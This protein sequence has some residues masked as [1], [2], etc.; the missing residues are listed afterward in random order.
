M[1]L[2]AAGGSAGGGGHAALMVRRLRFTF[3][4]LLLLGV[5]LSR[6]GLMV[7]V[8]IGLRLPPAPRVPHEHIALRTLAP[9]GWP[10][11]GGDRDGGVGRGCRRRGSCR[12]CRSGTAGQSCAR[13]SP[14]LRRGR[15]PRDR[16]RRVGRPP[17]PQHFGRHDALWDMPSTR[18]ASA[19]RAGIGQ[20]SPCSPLGCHPAARGNI[21]WRQ[22][23]QTGP[24]LCAA[25]RP[26]YLSAC[27]WR[28][29]SPQQQLASLGPIQIPPPAFY[30]TVVKAP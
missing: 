15:A 23:R 5:A 3:L 16:W 2:L 25:G 14:L 13:Q 19:V 11:V 29:R 17:A 7:F 28:N 27:L 18:V 6:T 20:C 26:R 8:F 12:H 1:L 21:P 4:P 9:A 22:E 24:P 30:A 10:L